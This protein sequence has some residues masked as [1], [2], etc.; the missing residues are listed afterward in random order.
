[1]SFLV[2]DCAFRTGDLDALR[3]AVE[4]VSLIPNGWL[5]LGIGYCF[6]YAIYHSPISFV[7]QLLD[8]GAD[9]NLEVDDGFPPL[10]AALSC[11]REDVLRLLL[12]RGADPNLQRGINDFTPLHM[13]VS[14]R[15]ARAALLLLDHGADP[16]ARTRVDDCE[17]PV[18][19]ASSSNQPTLVDLLTGVT[20]RLRPGLTLL[21]DITG[22]GEP[23]RRQQRYRIRLRMRLHRGDWV[24]WEDGEIEKTL[25][26]RI[27]RTSLIPGIFYSIDGMREGGTRRLEIA[28]HL[29]YGAA[30]IPGRIPANAV[31][32]VDV[33]VEKNLLT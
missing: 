9:P 13:A 4:E 14:Q 10:I 29:A 15:N 33:T 32:T 25:D 27:N 22:G 5:G 11:G 31:L 12:E 1:M 17:T 8:L 7:H 28:P 3:T 6:V 18:Q 24:P 30:G 21:T 26:V 19:M 23:V 16:T 2:I 20:R